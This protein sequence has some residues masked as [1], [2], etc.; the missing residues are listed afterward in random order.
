[1]DDD[2]CKVAQRQVAAIMKNIH[3]SKAASKKLK[4][5]QIQL[6]DILWCKDAG[7]KLPPKVNVAQ[8]VNP[9]A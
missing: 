8:F 9:G 4:T 3:D 5:L 7:D 2:L 6:G 1:M